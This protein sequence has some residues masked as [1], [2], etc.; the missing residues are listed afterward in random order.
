M[1]QSVKMMADINISQQKQLFCFDDFQ[2]FDRRSVV[3]MKSSRVKQQVTGV[4]L[5]LKR[6]NTSF[7]MIR[8]VERTAA[9]AT[10]IS[11]LEIN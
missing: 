9:N 4:W 6:I 8:A 7:L 2:P 11:T 5:C 3:V 1:L 10:T